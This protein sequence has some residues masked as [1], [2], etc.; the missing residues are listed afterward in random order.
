MGIGAL[1]DGRPAVGTYEASD[2]RSSG[3]FEFEGDQL[4]GIVEKPADPPSNRID[5]GAHIF[6][7]EAREWLDVSES[8]R[9]ERELTDVLARVV[10][11]ETVR[12]VEVDR[13]LGI[14]RPWELLGA[15]EW[16]LAELEARDEGDVAAD[17]ML[18]GA[19]VVERG[20]A[21]D[22]VR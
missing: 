1:L 13:W 9:G 19:V 4:T 20:A 17:A 16:K 14:G 5:V 2:P 21:V 15:N 7:A 12:A 3:L 6:L 22:R 8:E 18:W 11:E 10:R